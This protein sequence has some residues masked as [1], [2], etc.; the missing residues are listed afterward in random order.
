[1]ERNKLEG[2]FKNKL[3]GYILEPSIDARDR[4]QG[5]IQRKRRKILIRR[6]GI[7]ASVLLF[8]FTGIYSFRVL[9]TDKIDLTKGESLDAGYGA[10]MA[11]VNKI[12]DPGSIPMDEDERTVPE[13]EMAY[14]IENPSD[15]GSSTESSKS[16]Y[17]DNYAIITQAGGN[18]K[19]QSDTDQSSSVSEDP[20]YERLTEEQDEESSYIEYFV[21]DPD[22]KEDE[23]SKNLTSEDQTHE[24][25]KITIE[26]IVSGNKDTQ[27]ESKRSNFYSK[28][29]NMK[30]MDEVLSDIRTYKDRLFALDFK[31]EGKVN[32]EEKS[33]E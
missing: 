27:S 7:A 6:I 19:I 23:K 25:M 11:I 16:V 9:N 24:P 10:E 1:M 20:E 28:L 3:E 33:K 4:F 8:T 21:A 31:K 22:I 30:T 18:A 15:G 12:P 26:Y 2:L 5:L 29:D 13:S 14:N 17:N 32:N